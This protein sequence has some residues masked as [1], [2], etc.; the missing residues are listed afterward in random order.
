MIDIVEKKQC[1]GCQACY[2]ACPVH[3]IDMI[4]DEEGFL[5]PRINSNKCLKCNA[6]SAVCPFLDKTTN[7]KGSPITY[8]LYNTDEDARLKSSSGGFFSVLV[9]YVVERGGVVYGV[10]MNDDYKGC[11]HER[12]EN[13]VEYKKLFGSKYLQSDVGY[14]YREAKKDLDSGKL[15]LF[16][17]TPCQINGLLLFLKKEYPNLITVDFICHGVPSQLLWRK[18][19]EHIEKNKNG[20]VSYVNFR[21]KQVGWNTFGIRTRCGVYES[22]LS[23]H[24]DPYLIMFLKDVCLRPSCYSCVPKKSISKSDFTMGD[25]WGINEIEPKLNDGKGTSIVMVHSKKASLIFQECQNCF[26]CAQVDFQNSINHNKSYYVSALKPQ[27]RDT[28]YADLNNYEFSNMIKKYCKKNCQD[29]LKSFLRRTK[30][31]SVLKKIK[32]GATNN[33]EY[34]LRYTVNISKH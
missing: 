7:G 24:D 14:S 2:N 11:R 30:I 34:G 25:F 5:Y 18:Y 26:I 27:G 20:K 19:I 12:F 3:C 29:K 8:A 1:S 9:K 28:F 6:C 17:G 31:W 16:S 10:S 13:G 33:C 15:V 4:P 32:G 22:F 21:D 23:Q